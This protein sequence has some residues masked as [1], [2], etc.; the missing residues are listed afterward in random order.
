MVLM[1]VIAPTISKFIES[2]RVYQLTAIKLHST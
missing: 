2:P 1:E